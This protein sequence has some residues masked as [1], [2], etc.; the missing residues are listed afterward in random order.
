VVVGLTRVAVSFQEAYIVLRAFVIVALFPA[1]L[2][3]QGAYVPSP[4]NMA[5]REWFQDA[6][7]GMFIH[8]GISSLLMDG[9]W[10]MEN[11]AIR[12]DEYERIAV[13]F[14]PTRFDA[15]AWVELA[16]SAGMRYLTLVAKH[17]DGF[18]L[19]DSRVSDWDVVERTPFGRDIVKELADACS[20][21][22]LRMFVYYSQLDWH[23]PDYFPLGMTGHN[24][25]RSEAG[26]WERYL[27]YMD[28]QL[29][30]LFSNYGQLA[31]V[32][33]D[34]MW[35]RPS[36]NWRL[37]RTYNLIHELQPGALIIPNHHQTPRFGEDV[38]T[39]E[40][41]LPGANTAG[42]NA[43]AISA[44]LPLETSETI[45]ESWGFRLTDRKYKSVS[46]LVR[47]LVQAAGRNA[48]LLLNIGPLPDGT[49]HPEQIERLHGVGR[50][51]ERYGPSI[52]QTRGGPIT[53][54]LWGVTTHRGDTVY[55]HVLD[56]PDPEISIPPLEER[57]QAAH[58]LPTG[59]RVQ[60][61]ETASG[62]TLD[63]PPRDSASVD[64][65]IVLSLKSTRQ[66]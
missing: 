4:E 10:V 65:V 37:R 36:A 47:M 7:F 48:N 22:G 52:Y 14:N 46:D 49:I 50:W 25:G 20:R 43:A 13:G 45:G 26:E 9:E 29:R 62:I 59:D 51:L 60:F 35:D 3:A 44:D 58:L 30:E 5:S 21:H 15:D 63:L 27:G 24:A 34:G 33:F 53:P 2:G 19:W 31:G 64:Q 55:V 18:A 1:A 39:F 8:W 66:R 61:R 42:W 40:K 57:V 54:R 56:W 6:K 32:W 16:R 17:H 11:R 28:A 41:D 12:V 38:Q 23:H